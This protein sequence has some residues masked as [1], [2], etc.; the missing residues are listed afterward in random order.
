MNTT[1]QD[2]V[3][4][5]VLLGPGELEQR[6]YPLPEIGAE[7]GL[8]EVLACGLCGSDL[9]SFEGSKAH[10]YP[11]ILGHEVVGRVSHVSHT[12]AARWS[13]EVGDRVVV[14]EALPCMSCDLCRSG[15]H[16]LCVRLG[17]RYGDTGV[18]TEPGLWGGFATAMY[19]HPASQL[20]RVPDEVS[21]DV[22]TLFIP[23]SNGL[24]WMGERGGVRPG[25]RVAVIGPGQHGVASALAARRLGADEVV[26]VGTHDDRPR[27]AV[28]ETFGCRTVTADPAGSASEAIMD[29]LGGRAD[30]VM[31]MTPGA[32][33]PVAATIE[34]SATGGT[35]LWGGLKRGDGT[36]NIPVDL[37]I[38]KELNVRGL[39]ARP[40]WAVSAALE[41]LAADPALAALCQR[42]V[43][44]DQLADA[45][46]LA[47]SPDPH[48]RPLHIAVVRKK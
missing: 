47:T 41:W 18:A 21:D 26:L 23:L 30:V 20:H 35:V 11:V 28:A 12:Q 24:A 3:I 17:Y 45:F 16:R 48:V 29:S 38:R 33:A 44:Q 6:T 7:G 9:A 1:P 34:A 40:S 31:D 46:A 27:L 39:Y 32:T 22:A 14:E 4:A 43:P 5:Q 8:L 42:S 15:R 19:L 37:L 2:E 36:A 25:H 10:D 13:V